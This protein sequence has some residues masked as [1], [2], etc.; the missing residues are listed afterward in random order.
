MRIVATEHGVSM[1]PTGG[2]HCPSSERTGHPPRMLTA[3]GCALCHL[4]VGEV[5]CLQDELDA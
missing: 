2:P 4:E 3:A 5:K 1:F